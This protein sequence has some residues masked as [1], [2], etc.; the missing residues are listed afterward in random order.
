MTKTIVLE[1]WPKP[2]KHLKIVLACSG[3][4]LKYA[5]VSEKVVDVEFL[6]WNPHWQTNQIEVQLLN[7]IKI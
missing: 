1:F 2:V 6:I 3:H 5:I 4:V 7:Q